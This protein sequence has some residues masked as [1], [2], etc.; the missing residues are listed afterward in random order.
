MKFRIFLLLAI[1]VIAA[2]RFSRPSASYQTP[3]TLNYVESSVG[4]TPPEFGS[5]HTEFE[6]GDVNGDGNIDLASI[7]DHS[8]GA[9]P[10]L[11]GISIWLG[12]GTGQ[13]NYHQYGE[14]FGYGGIALGDVNGDGLMDV[15]Y[16]M[17]HNY[18]SDD[19][20]DQLI[21][22]ALGDGSGLSW[23]AWDDGLA[24]NNEDYGMFGTDFAD[25]DHDGDLDIGAVSFGYGQGVHI[26]LNQ[27]DGTWVQSFGFF[28]GNADNQFEFGDVN[29]DGNADFAS[30]H[31][32]G[33]VYLGDGTGTFIL[34]DGNLPQGNLSISLGDANHD[35]RDEAVLCTSSGGVKVWRWISP[36]VWENISGSL[37]S[38]GPYEAVQ[39]FDMDMDGNKDIAAFGNSQFRIWAG[40]DAGNWAELAAFNTPTPGY[41]QSFRV[42]GDVDHNGYPDIVLVEEEGAPYYEQNH[43]RV[44]KEAST[45]ALP[46]IKPVYPSGSETFRAGGLIFVDWV[47]AVPGGEAGS[48]S[49][50]LSPYGPGGP[51]QT[52]ASELPDNGR[53]QWR[54]PP[55]T[56][57][58][59]DVYIRYTLEITGGTSTA[60]TPGPFTIL[61]AP[62]EPVEGL[63]ASSDC[64]TVVGETTHLT[65]TVTAGTNIVFTWDLG[66]GTLDSGRLVSHIYPETGIFTAVV[67][68]TNSVS[69][70]VEITTVVVEPEPPVVRKMYLPL[71]FQEI[72]VYLPVH[73]PEIIS[74]PQS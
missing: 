6:M 25:V 1:L 58:S 41:M 39:V 48:V 21:E 14:N 71:I 5:G 26:Y 61:G 3:H 24:T 8:S 52:V 67:T 54:I 51:W 34:G 66:D 16:S 55:E 13:W 10:D 42:G 37:P 27:G 40:D 32:T 22:V 45:P 20:G 35:G 11:N 68:A 9:S 70:Q 64:P 17:H 60:I 65:A 2:G 36:G 62:E 30:N 15:G 28:D 4:L 18:T 50:E 33:E 57:S 7:G 12:D 47:S 38:S 46:E 56:P 59:N 53:Y 23:A 49:L 19:L 31:E 63:T 29:G 43:L 69:S 74:P 72:D 73:L 44:Y